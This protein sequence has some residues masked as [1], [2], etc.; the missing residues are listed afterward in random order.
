[1]R[2]QL[3]VT[4]DAETFDKVKENGLMV[5]A[6]VDTFDE[7]FKTRITTKCKFKTTAPYVIITLLDLTQ[8]LLP[9]LWSFQEGSPV[10]LLAKGE[11]YTLRLIEEQ[12]PS[13]DPCV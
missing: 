3:K 11:L 5:D 4:T 13:G 10:P 7:L 6:L 12:I 8:E 9:L 2:V 1:M